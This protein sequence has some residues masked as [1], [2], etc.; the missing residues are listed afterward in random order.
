[1]SGPEPAADRNG[2][3]AFLSA[4]EL[5]EAYRA[6]A[7]S[8]VAVAEAV[9]DR[10]ARLDPSLNALCLVDRDGALE[11]ARASERR[12][13]DG[14]PCGLVDGVPTTIKDIVLTRGWPTRR[15]SRT[16]SPDQAWDEDG[17]AVARLREHGAVLIGKTT[18]P[19]FAMKPVTISPLTGVTRNPWDVRRT[20]GGSSGGAAAAVAAGFGP[21]ALGTDAG[22]SIRIPASFCGVFGLKPSGG[23]VP[24]YPPT[25]LGTFVG[26]GPMTRSVADAARMLAVIAAPDIR[27]WTALPHDPTPYHERLDDCDPRRWRIAWSPTL[28]YAEVAPDV[29]AAAE[30]AVE[31][32]ARLG[33]KIETVE[34]V[35]DD[36]SD[37]FDRLRRG[38]TAFAF[39]DFGPDQFALMDADLVAAIEA[40]RGADLFGHLQAESE[41][42]ALGRR[43]AAFHRD[44]DLLLTPSVAVPAFAAERDGPPGWSR[45]AWTPFAHPFNL[46]RQP[47]A[48]LPCG[49]DA[50]GMPVGLQIVGPLYGDLLVLQASRAFEKARPWADRRPELEIR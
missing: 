26:F 43:M 20:S 15:G 31:A 22:G 48:S 44:Y 33:A 9:L 18:T 50:S 17:P 37:L 7:L 38:L 32:F 34:H 16:V 49:V 2:G 35:M 19:E 46:T 6:R 41:R 45:R 40:S 39:R 1:M 10:I 5:V 11:A 13:R 27:D 42:A 4:C 3:L 29:A 30:Q 23:R 36:A 28:G 21:L 47:A 25:P 14:A 24:T 12:W 8:P